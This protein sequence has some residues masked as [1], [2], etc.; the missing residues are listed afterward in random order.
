MEKVILLCSLWAMLVLGVQLALCLKSKKKII[1]RIP[2]FIIGWVYIVALILCLL[3]V[4]N[5]SGGVAIW[6]I[7]AF[8]I[9]IANT[10]T[11]AADGIAW[12]VYKRLQKKNA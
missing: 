7:F 2:I 1:K 3:D 8:I 12:I 4:L 9:S 10:V 5:G 11:L 6:S